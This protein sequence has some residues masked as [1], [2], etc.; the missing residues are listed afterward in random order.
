MIHF[1]KVEELC[2]AAWNYTVKGLYVQH[3]D[4]L[5]PIGDPYRVKWAADH[6]KKM[7]EEA[8]AE[9]TSVL[10]SI[11]NTSNKIEYLS[12]LQRN[13]FDDKLT[14]VLADAEISKAKLRDANLAQ[15]GALPVNV[16]A[17]MLMREICKIGSAGIGRLSKPLRLELGLLFLI[18]T[19]AD[20]CLTDIKCEIDRQKRYYSL[21]NASSSAV[22]SVVNNAHKTP[23]PETGPKV[24]AFMTGRPSDQE[25]IALCDRAALK[26]G[27]T[28]QCKYTDKASARRKIHA[29]ARGLREAYKANGSEETFRLALAERYCVD[30]SK[31]YDPQHYPGK[32]R[33]NDT[34]QKEQADVMQACR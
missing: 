29:L 5:L 27:L 33:P 14:Q 13:Y 22:G 4:D 6:V 1:A 31:G 34:W 20:E 32:G 26:I 16:R 21:V 10:T 12:E 3:P 18:A 8:R 23:G 28:T 19:E 15:V 2:K 7:H 25:R 9:I 24:A 30:Y 17:V 11:S